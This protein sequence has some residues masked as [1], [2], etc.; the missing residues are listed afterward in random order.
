MKI[1]SINVN[2]LRAFDEKNGN[3]FNNFCLNVLEAD[4]IC[5]QEIKGSEGSLSKYHALKDYQTFSSFFTK[6][7]HGVSTIV[8]KSL[9]CGKT[10]E[11]VPGRILKTDH[12]NFTIF[13]C[14]MPYYDESKE[15]DKT[16]IIKVY[17]LLRDKLETKRVVICGD[18]N[19]TYNMLDHYQFRSE[20]ETLT[21]IEKWIP[22]NLIENVDLKRPCEVMT[23]KMKDKLK[24][25]QILKDTA[26]E[27]A[28]PEL[29]KDA[30]EKVNPS[31]IELPFHFFT[32]KALESYFFE[33]YQRS[34][35]RELIKRYI[36]TFRLYNHD[37]SQYTCWNVMFNL[38]P[39]NLGTRIDYILCSEDMECI[40]SGIMPEMKGSDHCPVFSEFNI[41]PFEGK[42]ENLVKKKNN[43]LA[44]FNS[45]SKLTKN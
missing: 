12:G 41:E 43:L 17:D 42:Q 45:K 32:F 15:G 2:G 18:L 30:V 5:L 14:Y 10:E 29:V 9:F 33:V 40:G 35:M 3:D 24:M 44:F 19:A 22:H 25:Y 20:L 6:G 31:K 38:R 28:D 26:E 37:L 39:M 7:R 34:W 16:E 36:D 21:D 27:F 8:K 11:I 13:N 4:I 1:F 23:Q